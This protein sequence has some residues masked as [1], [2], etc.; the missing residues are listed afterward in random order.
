MRLATACDTLSPQ[1]PPAAS[2]RILAAALS[3]LLIKGCNQKTLIEM[4][5]S[6]GCALRLM[7]RVHPEGVRCAVVVRAGSQGP[8]CNTD[9]EGF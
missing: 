4:C 2:L 1:G 3:G 8:R 5:A 7:I 9:T 6:G